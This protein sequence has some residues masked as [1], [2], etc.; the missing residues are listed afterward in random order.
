L[1]L[2][3][4]VFE[5]KGEYNNTTLVILLEMVQNDKNESDKKPLTKTSPPELVSLLSM[6]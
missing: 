1:K 4:D 3:V 2:F 6:D 5:S